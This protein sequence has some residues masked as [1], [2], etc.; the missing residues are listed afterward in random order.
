MRIKIILDVLIILLQKP[1]IY[2][3][4]RKPTKS[5]IRHHIELKISLQ[6][7]IFQLYLEHFFYKIVIK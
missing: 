4:Y 7:D 2:H 6:H 1:A 3:K 5:H